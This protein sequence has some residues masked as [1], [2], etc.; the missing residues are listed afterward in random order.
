[1]A[2]SLLEDSGVSSAK[3][4][5]G[6]WASFSLGIGKLKGYSGK[7][8]TFKQPFIGGSKEETDWMTVASKVMEGANGALDAYEADQEKEVD[9]YLQSHSKEEYMEA[10]KNRGLPFQNDPIAM[11]VFKGKYAS[12][13]S[14]MAYQEFQTKL[15]SGEFDGMSEA[16]VDAEFFKHMRDA[17][18]KI[19]QET[20]GEFAGKTFDEAFFLDSPKKRALI[21]GTQTKRTRDLKVQQDQIAN[22]T[23]IQSALDNGTIS[24]AESFKTAIV[25]VYTTTGRHFTPKEWSDQNS[26]WLK[27][28]V[29]SPNAEAILNGLEGQEIPFSG[30]LK[31]DPTTI[32]TLI[33]QARKLKSE[34]NAS[35]EYAFDMEV[36]DLI[37]KRDIATF[38]LRIQEG[39]KQSGNRTT[40]RLDKLVKGRNKAIEALRKDAQKANTEQKAQEA[41]SAK[42]PIIDQ[43]IEG[44]TSSVVPQA[45]DKL[46]NTF[47][48]AQLNT[49]LGER[50]REGSISDEEILRG[51]N[52]VT[53]GMLGN[54]NPF[55]QVIDSF[56]TSAL[57]GVRGYING[58]V[59]DP[60]DVNKLGVAYEKL[61]KWY[62]MDP[63]IL[64]VVSNYTKSEDVKMAQAL[65]MGARGGG[66]D[67]RD[68][69]NRMRA[70]RI[71]GDKTKVTSS[72]YNYAS[73][74]KDRV[75][76]TISSPLDTYSL[77]LL[78]SL[79]ATAIAYGGASAGEALAQA[80]QELLTSH[81]KLGNSYIPRS[82]FNVIS[83]ATVDFV[84][85]KVQEIINTEYPDHGAVMYYP[86]QRCILVF[87]KSA[88]KILKK[89]YQGDI[90]KSISSAFIDERLKKKSETN[91]R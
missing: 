84:G 26:R 45:N 61:V 52:N 32:Q 81:F 46:T 35:E 6:Q 8:P 69:L 54:Q 74:L 79:G 42:I 53:V 50:I 43:W 65:L 88:N 55:A 91:P 59:K 63:N 31:Y 25:G 2:K 34:R 20:S 12:I 76:E 24:D 56:C 49:R 18:E 64:N 70:V 15:E 39:L 33:A 9:K 78:Y 10:I 90:E 30:G 47:T 73:T 80:K 28:L 83:G 17:K 16:Q 7:T 87:N 77:Q 48:I 62:E 19:A 3:N 44:A 4:A 67:L 60:P 5:W 57:R 75:A 71:L 66:A 1:M 85:G 21:M 89:Y 37:A 58:D 14:G 38:D 40:P 82:F 27:S 11:K 72:Q 13:Y 29:S 51:A 23:L 22:D 41:Y 36:A 86:N 68:V